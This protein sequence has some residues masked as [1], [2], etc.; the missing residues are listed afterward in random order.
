[1]KM[2]ISS[3]KIPIKLWLDDMESSAIDQAKNLANL[4]Y[5]FKHIAI[6]PDAH[7]GYGMPIGG[8]M[9]THKVIVPNAVGVDIGCGMC[10]V[11]T[12]L[13]HVTRDDVSKWIGILRKTIPLGYKHNAKKNEDMMP[14]IDERMTS[15]PIVQNEYD[16]ASKQ[17]GSLGGGNHFIE[18]QK[19]SDKHIW[20]M[21]H[22]GSRN[23]GK[24][25]ADHY[26][27]IAKNLNVM[28]QSP[29]PPSW[30]L[31]FLPLDSDEGKLYKHEMNY[32]VQFAYANRQIMLDK[33]K[34]ALLEIFDVEFDHEVNIAHNFAS[35]ENHFGQNVIVHRKGATQ[36]NEGLVGIIPGS[37]G[38]S[39]FIV[40]GKGNPDSFKSC[41]HGAGRTMGR[42]KAKER[43]NLEEEKKKLDD[44]GIV[45]SIR[46]KGDL[47][48][49]PGAYKDISVVMDNQS[50]LVDVLVELKPLGVLKG[51]GKNKIG[52]KK[53]EIPTVTY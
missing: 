41:S 36:A 43:L 29:I 10:A 46:G 37:Q 30:D 6:M 19:G 9:A 47:D 7:H 17:I 27:K 1:M 53:K 2:V 3:Q 31:A 33:M 45:H 39:S 48:E 21:V 11:R 8:V 28:W 50:D 44:L 12:N 4:P 26:I 13:T 49:A 23:I 20:L 22:S 52:K 35:I 40:R 51:P 38:T 15:L 42:A 14:E 18:I 5:A 16:S 25:V 32:C 34:E 24:K